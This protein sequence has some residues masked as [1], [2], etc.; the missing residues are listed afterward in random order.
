MVND[1]EPARGEARSGRG[2]RGEKGAAPR[3]IQRKG[4]WM[5]IGD[6]DMDGC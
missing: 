2:G 4:M 3:A 6:L 5:R 1:L